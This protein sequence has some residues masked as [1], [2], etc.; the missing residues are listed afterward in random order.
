M[1]MLL[2][3]LLNN[4]QPTAAMVVGV[5]ASA[6]WGVEF[7]EIDGF[8]YH[9]LV[10]GEALLTEQ[11]RLQQGNDFLLS[12]GALAIVAPHIPFKLRS[13]KTAFSESLATMEQKTVKIGLGWKLY[14]GGSGSTCRMICGTFTIDM[15][16]APILTP[17]FKAVT[18]F[19]QNLLNPR[20]T[21]LIE[22]I[23][24]ELKDERP[25]TSAIIQR[26]AEI[27]FLEVLRGFGTQNSSSFGIFAA[28]REPNLARSLAAFHSSPEKVWT[29]QALA[30]QSGMSIATF[31]RIFSTYLSVPPHEYVL[32]WRLSEAAR[33][34]CKTNQSIKSISEIVGFASHTSFNKAFRRIYN[35][36]PSTYRELTMKR[37]S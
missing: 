6:P 8:A 9:I 27:L 33:Q 18:V 22:L 11:S 35:C 7:T 23:V 28:I 16:L 37:F 32:R 25:G 17:A 13:G 2:K 10:E 19:E 26:Y 24:G 29:I 3:A 20:F 31:K 5:T 30:D 21:Q 12:A 36:S 4:I 15:A 34:L 14:E 1:Q